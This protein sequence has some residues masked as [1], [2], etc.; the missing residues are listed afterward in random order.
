MYL[1]YTKQIKKSKDKY[2]EILIC[3]LY[4][5]KDLTYKDKPIYR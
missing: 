5:I 2:N 4:C 3:L 1:Y